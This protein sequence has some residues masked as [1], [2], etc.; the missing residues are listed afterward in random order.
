MATTRITYSLPPHINPKEAPLAFG[1]LAIPKLNRELED[2]DLL[3][4]QKAVYSLCTLVHDPLKSY[5]ALNAG[6]VM[7]LKKLLNDKDETARYKSVETLQIMAQH[8]TC[9]MQFI[10]DQVIAAVA[11]LFDDEVE[12]VRKFAHETVAVLSEA[13]LGAHAVVAENLIPAL[14]HKLNIELDELKCIILDSLHFCSRINPEAALECGA[15]FV[16]ADLLYHV[17]SEIRYK[18]ARGIM[19]VC[20]PL[21]GKRQAVSHDTLV[22]TLVDL[23]VDPE[24]EVQTAAIGAI[25]TISI[26]TEGKY[27]HIKANALPAL[28]R[29]I[30]SESSETR[31]YATKALTCLAEAPEGRSSL[32]SYIKYRED[33]QLDKRESNSAV[34]RASYIAQKVITWKP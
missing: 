12:V 6:C 5:E 21:K 29:L 34:A 17:N 10:N 7:T 1:R 20:V 23:L 11:K 22:K 4:R 8:S 2:P 15:L 3:T 26:T 33:K 28:K 18:A 13:P 30:S 9:R 19:D 31:L 27:A 25:M 16:L 14:V 32:M 24:A